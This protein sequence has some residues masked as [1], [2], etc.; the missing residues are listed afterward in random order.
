MRIATGEI[1]KANAS[2]TDMIMIVLKTVRRIIR[3]VLVIARYQN[4]YV[5]A[6][7]ILKERLQNL[8]VIVSN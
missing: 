4:P 1:M 8:V 3:E 5:R 6:V 2:Y 7:K